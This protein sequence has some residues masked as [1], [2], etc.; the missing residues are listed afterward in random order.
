MKANHLLLQ[1]ILVLGVSGCA[2]APPRTEV[3]RSGRPEIVI[4]APVQSIKSAI[5]A[6]MMREGYTI[7]KDTDLLLEF[8]RPTKGAEDFLTS[9]AV[10]NGYST[11]T[12][13]TQ[14]TIVRDGEN[15]FRVFVSSSVQAQMP[16]G[17]V[18]SMSLN[19]NNN[20]FNTYQ[21]AL[22]KMKDDLE[23]KR[24]TTGGG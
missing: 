9:M 22:K 19:E 24:P 12:R 15:A 14:F 13:V 18:K 8:S 6:D 16:G 17:Q 2:T 11:N 4:A 21:A 5:V 10:G 1:G 23:A 7:Q 20:V 3:T